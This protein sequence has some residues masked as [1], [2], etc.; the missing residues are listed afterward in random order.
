MVRSSFR[1]GALAAVLALSLAPLA[2]ACAAGNDAQTL[3]VQPDSAQSST[4]DV[5]VQN[6]YVLTDPSGPSTVTARVFNNGSTPQTL[7]SIALGGNVTTTLAAPNGGGSV[8]VPAHGSVLLGGKGNASAVV[9]S[10]GESLRNGDV[11][12]ATFTFSQAG[13][14][15]LPVNV[16]PAAGFF[17]P[18]GPSSAPTTA[19]ATPGTIGQDSSAGQGGTTTPTTKPNAPATPTNTTTPTS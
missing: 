2:A 17:A 19:T 8:V 18:Y 6:A 3:E 14:V 10:G 16:T 13:A 12:Q 11:Q 9:Q 1:R 7:Q 5:K 4:S 15:S